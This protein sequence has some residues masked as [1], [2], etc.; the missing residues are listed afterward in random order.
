[1]LPVANIFGLRPTGDRIRETLF[2]WLA[3]YLPE[4][5]CLDLFAGSGALGFEALSRGAQSAIMVEANPQAAQQ[6]KLNADQLKTQQLTVLCDHAEQFLRQAPNTAFDIVFIDPP[7][8]L[9]LWNPILALLTEQTWL[10][11]N[12]LIYVETPL[13]T[14]LDIPQ[15]WR[16]IKQKSAG[17]VQFALYQST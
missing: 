10:A 1:M 8:D 17:Q 6:L 7:F 3:P 13:N 12:A 2:N 5:H 14:P 9:Q 4:S 15:Q 16:C 11:P